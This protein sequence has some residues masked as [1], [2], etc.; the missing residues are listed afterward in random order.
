MLQRTSFR[1][2]W[3][4]LGLFVVALAIL[5]IG[6]YTRLAAQ[7][8]EPR[9]SFP[10]YETFDTLSEVPYE[11]FGGD[12]EIRD[13]MLVQLSTDGF[14]LSAFV[15]IAVTAEQPYGAE[16]TLR[17]LGGSMGGGIY[18][19]AQQTTS[20]QKSHMVR[21]NVDNGQLWLIYGYFGDD[22]DFI[23]QGSVPLSMAPD[24]ADPHK[25]R[26]EVNENDYDLLIDD[27]VVAGDIP[28]NY[29]G[30]AVGFIT[31]SSQVAFD[32]IAINEIS[33]SSDVAEQPIEQVTEPVVE[34]TDE[35][36]SEPTL[37]TSAPDPIDIEQQRLF[38]DSFEGPAGGESLWLPI[39]GN[40]AYQD[41]TFVQSQTDGFDLSAIYQRPV[42]YPMTMRAT[43]QHRDGVGGG[44]LF[45]IPAPDN[46]NGGHMI[47]YIDTGDVIAWGYFDESGVFNGQGSAQVNLPGQAPHT[48]EIRTQ[49]ETYDVYLDNAQLATG[50]PVNNPTSPSYIGLTSSQSVVAFE[51]VDVF[52]NAPSPSIDATE[53]VPTANIDAEAASGNWTVEGS[54]ITQSDVEATDYVAGTGLG[55]EQFNI[56]ADIS[57][58]V[59]NPDA[60]AGIIFHMQGRDDRGLAHMVRFGSN[61]QELF[62]GRYDAD[63]IFT[64][65]G[66]IPL[67]LAPGETYNLLLSVHTDNFD[68][69]VN[70]ETL[71]EAIPIQRSSGWIGLVSFS[72]PVVFS[73]VNMQLGQ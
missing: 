6:L 49:G 12:W 23:G 11:E 46:K 50:I 72:G 26:V 13:Q 5:N 1:S 48:L 10:Y 24:N 39:T 18:F 7:P 28:L 69:Q 21:F 71:V 3:L 14:D 29:K 22:S 67:E 9:F 53:S 40:W 68:I 51:Q 61:G 44:V 37:V 64:G 54:T 36:G 63:G 31:A 55:G 41:G 52:T 42:T 33:Q 34:P 65:E 66:G 19:N 59:D 70:G 2:T 17:Y 4:P 47:R 16:A 38:G 32:N 15:P 58:P 25:L 60:G 30:G 56:S 62:W 20:R 35:P 45:N 73:N 27:A 57:L 8:I 43:F